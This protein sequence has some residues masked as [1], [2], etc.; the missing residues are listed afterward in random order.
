MCDTSLAWVAGEGRVRLLCSTR[1]AWEGAGSCSPALPG[2]AFSSDWNSSP[3]HPV[4]LCSVWMPLVP[5][6]STA[7]T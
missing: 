6:S 5:R 1:R 7:L 3:V 2:G 4:P